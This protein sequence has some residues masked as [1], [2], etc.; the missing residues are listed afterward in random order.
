MRLDHPGDPSVS[1]ESHLD[2]RG[3]QREQAR[4]GSDPQSPAE[5]RWQ[6]STTVQ[7]LIRSLGSRPTRR[8][9]TVVRPAICRPQPKR[10]GFG[11][12]MGSRRGTASPSWRWRFL[13]CLLWSRWVP[14]RSLN[15]PAPSGPSTPQPATT[16]LAASLRQDHAPGLPPGRTR[17]AAHPCGAPSRSAEVAAPSRW[18]GSMA[19]PGAR[20]GQHPCGTL[21]TNE[22]R[23][24][25]S[26]R[27]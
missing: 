12:W 16:R 6:A 9:T 10:I 21:S 20:C 13:A 5:D 19:G 26:L 4:C 27:T 25:N 24:G 22:S 3:I 8:A 15:K 1:V 17:P 2:R 11:P 23:S 14:L 7:E 18:P